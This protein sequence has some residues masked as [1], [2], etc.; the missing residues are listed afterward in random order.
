MAQFA[1][2]T[3]VT[4]APGAQAILRYPPPAGDLVISVH[5]GAL[6]GRN[7][8]TTAVSLKG[9]QIVWVGALDEDD[10]K[11]TGSAAGYR[12]ASLCAHI[13][14]GPD[15]FRVFTPGTLVT[16][17]A[18]GHHYTVY[19]GI[20]PWLTLGRLPNGLLLAVPLSDAYGNPKWYAPIIERQHLRI[21]G[22][23]KDSQAEL[24]H[25]WSLPAPA[26]FDGAVA[27]T[28]RDDLKRRCAEYFADR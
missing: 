15:V 18:G 14:A 10:L 17:E 24:A 25:L 6:K 3:R 11:A 19:R 2:G 28:I 21:P 12:R 13:F 16:R 7:T 23:N 26:K 8:L 20:R 5:R 27:D 4:L 9:D 1:I 22:S